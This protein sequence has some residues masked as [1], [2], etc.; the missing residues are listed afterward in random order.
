MKN[1]FFLFIF[2]FSLSFITKAQTVPDTLLDN[3]KVEIILEE[4]N[5][6]SGYLI[7]DNDTEVKIWSEKFGYLK[8]PKIQIKE[9]KYIKDLPDLKVRNKE[10]TDED[11]LHHNAITNSAFA[12]K[13]GDVYIRTPYFLVGCL[14]YGITDKLTVGL[15]A[16]YFA[17][18]NLN[19]RYSFRLSEKSKLAVGLGAYYTYF[20]GSF[21]TDN[22]LLSA[23]AI[24]TFGSEAR[25]FSIGGTFLTN[26]GRVETGLA[27]FSSMTKISDR[28]YF[29]SDIVFA[30][31]VRSLNI[32][33]NYIGVGF[34]GIRIKTRR[35]NRIDLGLAN[36]LMENTYYNHIGVRQFERIFV[37]LPYIQISYKL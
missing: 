3:K 24:Y 11:Y 33:V 20:G 21:S 26:F 14:D 5:T 27:H 17:A 18:L 23:R 4:G 30:P 13:R 15:D 19:L 9:I 32:D 6:K 35:Q 8:I 37:P 22:S 34:L 1:L 29:L 25:N 36:L 10:V 31:S 16:F 28:V 7:H 12:P 2:F